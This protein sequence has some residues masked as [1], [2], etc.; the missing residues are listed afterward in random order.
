MSVSHH[1]CQTLERVNWAIYVPTTAVGPGAINDIHLQHSRF[2]SFLASIS[3]GLG[4]LSRLCQARLTNFPYIVKSGRGSTK[5]CRRG[6]LSSRHI[7][8]CPCNVAATYF[9]KMIRISCPCKCPNA[10]LCLLAY[11]HERNTVTRKPL[12]VFAGPRASILAEIK[13]MGIGSMDYP[14]ELPGL[15][16]K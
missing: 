16:V 2:L 13:V 3:V 1:S 11:V 5:R 12:V 7:S 6:S 15:I 10:F 8:L 14:S 4:G 9:L